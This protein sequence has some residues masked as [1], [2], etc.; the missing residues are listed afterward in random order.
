MQ[1][2]PFNAIPCLHNDAGKR[3][4]VNSIG[5][6]LQNVKGTVLFGPVKYWYFAK[7][8]RNKKDKKKNARMVEKKWE[9]GIL[10]K[11]RLDGYNLDI[12]FAESEMKFL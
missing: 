11:V 9:T 4:V 3:V 5:G 7:T 10:W 8:K 2:L 1:N 6:A 12:D